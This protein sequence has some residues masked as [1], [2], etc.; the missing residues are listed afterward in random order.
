MTVRTLTLQA[1]HV[2]PCAR[3]VVCAGFLGA[4]D[5]HSCVQQQLTAKVSITS[6]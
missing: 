5:R 4:L 3:A 2:P 6:S 1:S